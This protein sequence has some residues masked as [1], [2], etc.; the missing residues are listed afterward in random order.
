MSS[1]APVFFV[2][3]INFCT[4]NV[5]FLVIGILT[6][7]GTTSQYGQVISYETAEWSNKMITGLSSTTSGSCPSGS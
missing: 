6:Y 2:R 5:A 7:K 1:L 3:C 4:F